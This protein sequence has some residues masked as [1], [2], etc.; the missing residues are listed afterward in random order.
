MKQNGMVSGKEHSQLTW[1]IIPRTMQLLLCCSLL[2]HSQ[3]TSFHEDCSIICLL[4]MCL[5]HKG[6]MDYSCQ[7]LSSGE[8][9]RLSGMKQSEMGMEPLS[10]CTDLDRWLHGCCV[11]IPNISAECLLQQISRNKKNVCLYQK[12][13]HQNPSPR[14]STKHCLRLAHQHWLLDYTRYP[15]PIAH[16]CPKGTGSLGDEQLPKPCPP[17]TYRDV[18]QGTDILDCWPCPAGTYRLIKAAMSCIQCDPGMFCPEG[19]QNQTL[20]PAGEIGEFSKQQNSSFYAGVSV[21]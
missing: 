8:M 5:D 20:C 10:N 11:K 3:G 15:C 12:K 1:R 16:F 9:Q 21:E 2:G 19:T 4:A 18:E 6:C 14:I 7:E 17:G 13:C